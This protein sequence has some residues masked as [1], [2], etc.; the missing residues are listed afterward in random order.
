[1]DKEIREMAEIIRAENFRMY[2]YHDGYIC[3]PKDIATLLIEKE[4]YRKEDEV[5]KETAKEIFQRLD[6][7][8]RE[9]DMI[10]AFFE[11]REYIKERY[12]VEVKNE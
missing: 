4:G 6:K 9:R 5:R 12:G 11:L 1:M 2:Q 3:T 8:T 7:L 10:Y